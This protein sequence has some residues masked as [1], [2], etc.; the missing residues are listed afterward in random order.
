MVFG[1]FLGLFERGGGNER[2]ELVGVFLNLWTIDD[3][4]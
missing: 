1:G 4:T 2:V 3:I